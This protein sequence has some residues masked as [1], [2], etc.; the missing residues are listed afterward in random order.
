LAPG[1]ERGLFN[2]A[3]ELRKKVRLTADKEEEILD[4][5]AY[6][7]HG[8]GVVKRGQGNR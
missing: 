1:A 2:N 4:S 3:G 5:M 8:R 6:F 7:S